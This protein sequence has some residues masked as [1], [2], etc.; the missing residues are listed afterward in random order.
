MT[1]TLDF[2][3]CVEVKSVDSLLKYWPFL[4]EG[5]RSLNKIATTVAPVSKETLFQICVDVAT[6]HD[7]GRLV[8]VLDA[9]TQEP[10]A[11]NIVIDNTNKYYKTPTLL[12]YAIYSNG[13]RP[14]A[15]RFGLK[16]SEKWAKEQG[17]TE[18]HG[19]S[20]RI[21]G[22]AVR[23]FETKFGYNKHSLFLTKK[24]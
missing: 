3:K 23:L 16:H 24:L 6:N 9:S 19:Y 20:Q 10:V 18:M 4:Q 11:Y 8:I 13:K 1:E 14:S 7:L 21:T 5:L 22:A 12:V 17:Y 2:L 15:S